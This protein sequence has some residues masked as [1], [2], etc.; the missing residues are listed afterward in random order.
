M[1][2]GIDARAATEVE[3]GRGRLV[4]ELLR[5]LA[6][7]GD[8]HTYLCYARTR[9][10]E[11]LDERFRWELIEAPDPLWHLR[12]AVAASRRCD[13]FLSTNSYLTT[14]LLR[15]PT[16]TI[17]YDLMALDPSTQ[18]NRRSA[19]VERLTLRGAIAASDRLWCI[20]EA[21]AA[22]LVERYPVARAKAVV[23]PLAASPELFQPLTEPA[24]PA[25]SRAEPPEPAQQLPNPGVGEGV[26]ERAE[27]LPDSG[28]VLAVGTLE[29]RKNVPRLVEA[30]GAL[31][32]E[33]QDAHPLV[34]VGAKGWRTG[35]TLE[36]LRSL[37]S[38]CQLLGHVSD[39]ELAELYR[40]CAV[41]CYPSLGE[42]FGLPILEAMA[43]GAP[44]V[45]SNV[46]SL[47]EV[48]G[49]AVEYVD[50]QSVPS[51]AAGLERVLTSE[52]RAAEFSERGRVRARSFS[53]DSTAEQ[54]VGLLE[55]AAPPP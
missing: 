20:S 18:P 4:R 46:S 53:W 42:G 52:G 43:A 27:P 34:V 36:S 12:A 9:W 54:V 7:R 3:A 23:I 21:T 49:D 13:V 26:F 30:Y 35:D 38:R 50:P 6:R 17:V 48:G 25:E 16:V 31:P 19:I 40:R 37:G 22:S 45:T 24:E 2:V 55:R 47:L 14:I 39:A 51:I 1:V 33:L 44:V 8:R 32:R 28:F 29:P 10:P 41:F 5:A 15:I 11:P